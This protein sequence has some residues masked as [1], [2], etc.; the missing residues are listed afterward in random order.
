MRFSSIQQFFKKLTQSFFIFQLKEEILSS[1]Q[2]IRALTGQLRRRD[3]Q[4]R[5]SSDSL[6]V[7]N[8]SSSASSSSSSSDEPTTIAAVKAGMLKASVQVMTRDLK[9]SP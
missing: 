9:K 4:R 7:D 6:D 1:Y 5:N 8:V 2:Q 3:K